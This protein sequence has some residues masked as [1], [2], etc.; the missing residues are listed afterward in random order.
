MLSKKR[1]EGKKAAEGEAKDQPVGR[2]YSAKLFRVLSHLRQNRSKISKSEFASRFFADPDDDADP[3]EV[4]EQL[5]RNVYIG[6][7]EST[8]SVSF[9]HEMLNVD[10]DSLP[11]FLAS[12]RG[13][14]SR[15]ELLEFNPGLES[16]V[17][18]LLRQAEV[19]PLLGTKNSNQRCLMMFPRGF[20]F[21]VPLSGKV[22]AKPDSRFLQ[23]SVDLRG[24]V[25][26]GDAIIIEGT[27]YRV[28]G[29]PNQLAKKS[30][31]QLRRFIQD[32]GGDPGDVRDNVLLAEKARAMLNESVSVDLKKLSKNAASMENGVMV[33][34]F[35]SSSDFADKGKKEESFLYDFESGRLPLDRPYSG[36][37][38][39][40]VVVYKYGCTEDVRSVY[41]QVSSLSSNNFL[42]R[43]SH[44]L[45]RKLLEKKIISKDLLDNL[46]RGTRERNEARARYLEASNSRASKK[47]RRLNIVRK[48]T[49]THM[50]QDHQQFE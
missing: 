38:L 18:D 31:A 3:N 7:D 41:W 49:N 50:D 15:E 34:A 30:V 28:S 35:S 33:N 6:Y 47:P 10:K 12:K 27:K 23:T 19:L 24:E 9:Q 42:P 5:K 17:N 43:D 2:D 45:D 11:T 40:D 26:R 8:D 39:T 32:V 46:N 1:D 25:R 36:P 44:A 48:I 4:W 22:S 16:A 37:P 29:E 20:D 21:R 14:V 13:G